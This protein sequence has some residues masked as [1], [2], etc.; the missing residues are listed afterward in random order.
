MQWFVQQPPLCLDLRNWIQAHPHLAA[1]VK[2]LGDGYVSA[3][4]PPVDLADHT[5]YFVNH[6]PVGVYD[7][8][9]ATIKNVTIHSPEGFLELVD[10][11]FVVETA[12][13][14][15][16]IVQNPAYFKR[17]KPVSKYQ[18]GKWFS[19][20]LF[21]GNGYYHWLCDVLPRLHYVLKLLPD[22]VRFIVPDNMQDWQRR[23]LELIGVP[24]DHCVEFDGKRPW[25]LEQF[26]YAPPVAM[27]GDHDAT[28]IQNV[29]QCLLR[30][31]ESKQVKPERLRLWISRAKARCRRI[32]NEDAILDAMADKRFTKIYAEDYS[33]E[34]QIALFQQAEAIVAPH[35]AGLTNMLFCQPG[36]KIL[37]I[38]EPSTQRRCYWSLARAL[39]H[40]YRCFIGE[41]VPSGKEEPDI[42]A[43]S[44]FFESFDI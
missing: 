39:G 44:Y 10:S 38:F 15:E 4:A 20:L 13:I 31:I 18:P 32:V 17:F 34:E 33:F 5:V 30:A 35:G 14:K 11:S 2:E 8:Y 27:T 42:S 25:L 16:N 1:I 29:S 36:T 37:E 40:D 9:L 23:S 24:I 26:Y 19:C 28:S 41:A 6:P 7:R 43:S 22:D 21:W 12:W 3:Y